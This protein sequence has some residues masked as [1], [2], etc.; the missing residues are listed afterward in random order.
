MA[1]FGIVVGGGRLALPIAYVE[2]VFARPF[3]RECMSKRPTPVDCAKQGAA[4][5]RPSPCEERGGVSVP[6]TVGSGPPTIRFAQ[7]GA[8]YCVPYALAVDYLVG[9][10]NADEAARGPSIPR[11]RG[12]LVKTFRSCGAARLCR[13]LSHR[14]DTERQQVRSLLSFFDS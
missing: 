9:H 14:K 11:S 1:W 10:A 6:T 7:G 5:R 8:D 13:S 3:V 2:L 12:V 4:A